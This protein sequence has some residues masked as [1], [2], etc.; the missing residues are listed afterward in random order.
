MI[1]KNLLFLLT[2]SFFHVYSLSRV[3][4]QK[5]RIQNNYDL[6]LET[7]YVRQIAGK[8]LFL[9]AW[10]RTEKSS[11]RLLL[12][13]YLLATIFESIDFGARKSQIYSL[14]RQLKDFITDHQDALDI[15]DRIWIE[16]QLQ[17][18]ENMR[19]GTADYL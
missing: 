14:V 16:V 5:Q 4:S 9:D 11:S 6:F 15:H 12:L 17:N 13:E 3:M 18:F 1:K 10:A 2:I 7:F 19:W 8:P